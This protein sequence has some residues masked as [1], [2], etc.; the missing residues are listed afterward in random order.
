MVLVI[1]MMTILVIVCAICLRSTTVMMRVV[2]ERGAY[3]QQLHANKALLDYVIHYTQE[4]FTVLSD[5]HASVD[6]WYTIQAW[7]PTTKEYSAHINIRRLPSDR[8][9]ITTQL[10]K[11]RVPVHK[12][13]CYVC[14]VVD[15]NKTFY[16]VQEWQHVH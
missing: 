5:S 12:L 3:Q 14:R 16:H 1:S 6:N 2:Y 10:F 15:E 13:Q 7:P 11:Q 8:L 4:Q 9:M